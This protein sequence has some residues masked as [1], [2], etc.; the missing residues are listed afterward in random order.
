M[1]NNQVK[2]KTH[3]G[4][5][6]VYEMKRGSDF[7]DI[8]DEETGALDRVFTK[9]RKWE[10]SRITRFASLPPR[11]RRHIDKTLEHE[12]NIYTYILWRDMPPSFTEPAE[13]GAAAYS[14]QLEAPDYKQVAAHDSRQQAKEHNLEVLNTAVVLTPTTAKPKSFYVICPQKPKYTYNNGIPAV[15][16]RKSLQLFGR[17]ITEPLEGTEKFAVIGYT[18]IE[19]AL[20]DYAATHKT[21]FGEAKQQFWAYEIAYDSYI[22]PLRAIRASALESQVYCTQKY[23]NNVLRWARVPSRLRQKVVKSQGVITHE[24]LKDFTW[25]ELNTYGAG[26]NSSFHTKNY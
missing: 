17:F 22:V 18:N 13:Q 11:W 3:G 6:Y 1:N 21:F 26:R 19:D 8:P 23:F 10:S 15:L 7:V 20:K 25:K 9:T 24:F 14:K 5:F 16:P 4:T 12:N 2:W